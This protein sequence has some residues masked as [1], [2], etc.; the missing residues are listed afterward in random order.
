M[1]VS[2]KEFKSMVFSTAGRMVVIG[3][4]SKS[5][6]VKPSKNCNIKKLLGGGRK[7]CVP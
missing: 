7:Q 6:Q 4:L 5:D 3:E 2:L 1:V